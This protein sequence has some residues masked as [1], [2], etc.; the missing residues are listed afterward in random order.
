[1]P[2]LR[3]AAVVAVRAAS[4]FGFGVQNVELGT[5]STSEPRSPGMLKSV[6]GIW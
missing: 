3:V 6:V 1:M 2:G 4:V 5:S